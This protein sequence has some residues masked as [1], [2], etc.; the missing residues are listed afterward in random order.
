[1]RQFESNN[2]YLFIVKLVHAVHNTNDDDETIHVTIVIV[3][4][5][6]IIIKV[7]QKP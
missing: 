4:K 7:W 6:I 2:I 1:M 5:I 3:N